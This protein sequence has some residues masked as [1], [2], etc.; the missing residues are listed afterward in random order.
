MCKSQSYLRLIEI[1]WITSLPFLVCVVCLLLSAM[2]ML[3]TG[4]GNVAEDTGKDALDWTN[5]SFKSFFQKFLFCLCVN[6][7]NYIL[8]SYKEK[9]L[10]KYSVS[11]YLYTSILSILC[12]I[13]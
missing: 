6:V 4:V 12:I 8:I 1:F 5:C 9:N 13:F 10:L 3:Y 11:E 2:T 7:I